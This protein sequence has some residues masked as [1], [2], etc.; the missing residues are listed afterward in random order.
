MFIAV[1]IINQT[2]EN[3]YYQ[4]IFHS[5]P[6]IRQV[7]FHQCFTY[8][9]PLGCLRPGAPGPGGGG[10]VAL[11][12]QQEVVVVVHVDVLRLRTLPQVRQPAQLRTI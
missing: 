4:L 8:E 9:A 7:L 1:K 10:G 6:F 3:N 5:K 12:A 11:E 2:V